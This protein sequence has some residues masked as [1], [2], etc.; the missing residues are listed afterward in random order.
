M[1][2][3]TLRSAGR[4]AVF[5]IAALA[6]G[7]AGG[8]EADL[9]GRVA[10]FLVWAHPPES[11]CAPPRIL[12][13]E[14]RR[15]DGLQARYEVSCGGATRLLRGVFRTREREMVW[16]V[17]AGYEVA[18]GEGGV[19]AG[20]GGKAGARA[21]TGSGPPAVPA[22]GSGSPAVPARP[23]PGT[24]IA[25]PPEILEE[26][27]GSVPD[28]FG[29]V[30]PPT[31]LE[32][33]KPEYPEEAGRA[34]LIGEAR[35][36]VLVDLGPDGRPMRTRPL[37]GPDPDLGMRQAA[38]AAV[39]R[40]RF[41]P[42]TLGGLP[43]RYFLPLDI[44]FHGLPPESRHWTH[45]ALYELEAVVAEDPLDLGP[46]RARVLAGEPF[47][48]VAADLPPSLAQGGDW[49]LVPAASL[50]APVR[51]ALHEARLHALVGPLEAE[52]LHYLLRKRGE[53][54]YAILPAAGGEAGY[55]VV[56]QRGGPAGNE[57]REAVVSDIHA[58]LAEDRRLAY[59]ND[60]ARLMGIRQVRVE[61]GQL[62]IHTDVLDESELR[63]LGGVMGSLFRAHASIWAPVVPPRPF[64][65]QVLVY[66]FGRNADYDLLHRLLLPGAAGGGPGRG[67]GPDEVGPG[68]RGKY[69]P[70]SRILAIS[71]EDY[72]GHLPVPAL[73]H[74]AVHMLNHERI[75]DAGARPSHWF[76]EGMATY[77]GASQVD[78]RLDIDPGA[79]RRS[80]TIVAGTV[81]L[82]F[83]PRD[84]LIA[85]QRVREE[86]GPVSLRDLV[87]A[88]PG[89]P[90]W[91]TP[92]VGR[93]YGAAWT[94]VHFLLHGEKGR[95]RARF[96]EYAALEARGAGGPEEF[97]RLLGPI[98]A[99]ETAWHAYEDHL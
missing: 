40:F 65:Q 26:A 52:G 61:S 78:G 91:R 80:G 29:A 79:I 90:A 55:R 4:H 12:E 45:R 57:L 56:H 71:C 10:E 25:P 59:M 93:T 44:G 36:T 76:E 17:A 43:V 85:Y 67:W 92:A 50:P 70:A 42:A 95:R 47:A 21:A 66:L 97:G 23:A 68:R 24:R 31:V 30:R 49:G 11:G 84:Q 20:S 22:T 37:R 99:L 88:G 69:I 58:F 60:A 2:E 96:L 46:F 73:L 53:V 3:S 7:P 33:A 86:G 32:E 64:G 15:A 5:V 39:R 9:Q 94:L 63:I 13:I 62:L 35:V 14:A 18:L 54:Y 82:Q 98:E 41:A 16:Q 8:G 89:D 19:V 72:G 48:A 74:E 38:A 28:P 75:Y 6:A 81:R 77:F 83:D 87:A 51:L 27:P 34:R 1:F